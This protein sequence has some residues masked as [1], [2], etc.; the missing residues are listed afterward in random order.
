MIRTTILDS[1]QVIDPMR[2]IITMIMII[3]IMM[4]IIILVLILI[5]ILILIQEN[6]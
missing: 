4:I 1:R 2:N 6:L 5:L 3:I